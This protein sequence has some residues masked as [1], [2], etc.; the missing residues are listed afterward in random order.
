MAEVEIPPVIDDVTY[1]MAEVGGAY[2]RQTGKYGGFECKIPIVTLIGRGVLHNLVLYGAGERSDILARQEAVEELGEKPEL[3]ETLSK[4]LQAFR[5]H[6]G[7]LY[8]FRTS[9]R[10]SLGHY[11]GASWATKRMLQLCQSI[12]EL[13]PNAPESTYLREHLQ[14]V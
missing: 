12:E 13:G 5:Q 7:Q 9:E 2:S 1:R 10:A 3:Y 11:Q 8:D 4:G 6:E 14:A